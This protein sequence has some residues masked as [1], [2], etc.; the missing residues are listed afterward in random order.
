MITANQMRAQ[1]AKNAAGLRDMLAKAQA[2]APRKYR[3]YTVAD[4]TEMLARYEGMANGTLPFGTRG[5]NVGR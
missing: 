5:P 3:G 1:Y 4:L 2:V